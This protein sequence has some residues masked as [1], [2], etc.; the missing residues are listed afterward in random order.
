MGR[1]P[2]L[3]L[4]VATL[5]L[6]HPSTEFGLG[7]ELVAGRWVST[8]LCSVESGRGALGESRGSLRTEP[9]ILSNWGS[10]ILSVSYPMMHPLED[11]AET[12]VLLLKRKKGVQSHRSRSGPHC[13]VKKVSPR[14][15]QACPRLLYLY[16]EEPGMLPSG[17]LWYR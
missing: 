8:T 16:R 10:S 14:K 1:L 6:P 17:V 5:P 3:A 15:G 9:Q 4:L 7:E 12:K 13:A 11:W 2:W